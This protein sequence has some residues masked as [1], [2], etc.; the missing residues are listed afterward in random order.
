MT[1]Y[2]VIREP[3]EETSDLSH[4]V[5][6]DYPS[7]YSFGPVRSTN[8]FPVGIF[9]RVVLFA[10]H[11]KWKLFLGQHGE[12]LF[13]SCAC[14]GITWHTMN[15]KYFHV[16]KRKSIGWCLER[17]KYLHIGKLWHGLQQFV[18]IFR[19]QM[20]SLDFKHVVHI[21]AGPQ[22]FVKPEWISKEFTNTS[23]TNWFHILR[24][25]WVLLMCNLAG[26]SW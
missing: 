19:D 15:Q 21:L 26:Q 7:T 20:L 12:I 22:E 3:S 6:L 14:F 18:A 16:A 8:F 1:D 23:T 4:L 24:R 17:L 9:N 10:A 13:Y 25:V 5:Y 11:L 2:Q